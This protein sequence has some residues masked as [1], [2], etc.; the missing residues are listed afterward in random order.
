MVLGATVATT[1]GGSA[2][3]REGTVSSGQSPVGGD[4]R[5]TAD[6]VAVLAQRQLVREL[7]DRDGRAADDAAIVLG[8]GAGIQAHLLG[9]PDALLNASQSAG[10]EQRQQDEGLHG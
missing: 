1:Y 3:H 4:N 8:A 9:Q 6:V 5:G 7:A 10:N 2:R